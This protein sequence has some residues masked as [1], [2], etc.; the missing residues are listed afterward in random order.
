[1]FIYIIIFYSLLINNSINANVNKCYGCK[2]FKLLK[3]NKCYLTN[4]GKVPFSI[5]L[6]TILCP[7][8]GVFMDL[9]ATGWLNIVL[10]VILTF[11]FYI[12][13]LLYALFIIYS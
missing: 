3:R 1:M 10:C 7:P 4:N 12:P 11:M 9:G 13:G 6:G 8:L 5:L 2:N